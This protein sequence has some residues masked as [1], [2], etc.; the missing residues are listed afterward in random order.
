ME[1][2]PQP[3]SHDR[4]EQRGKPGDSL[5]WSC[6]VWREH[7][8]DSDASVYAQCTQLLR[9]MPPICAELLATEADD[10]SVILDVA[11]FYDGAYCDFMMPRSLI[12]QLA[13]KGVDFEI[14][15]YPVSH[16]AGAEEA[17]ETALS[18]PPQG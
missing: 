9:E 14:T 4:G 5:I 6:T 18:T 13:A 7:A 1:R 17:P 10:I 12:G 3:G 16:S 8:R 2:Q 11:V 15:A